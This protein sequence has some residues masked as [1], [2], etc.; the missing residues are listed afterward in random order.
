VAMRTSQLLLAISV[1]ASLTFLVARPFTAGDWPV[2]FEVLSILLL[3]MLGFRCD[4]L[5]GGALVISSVGD[6]LLGIPRLGGLDGESL[7]LFGLGSFLVAHILYIGVFLKYRA[8]VWRKPSLARKL[9]VLVILVA[10]A[11]VL[12]I[13]RPSL[14]SMLI[15]VMAYSLVLCCMGISAMLADLGN[16]LAGLG[17]LLFIAS[18]AMLAISKFRG[19]FAGNAQLIWITYYS[20]QFLILLGVKHRQSPKGWIV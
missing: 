17:A 3:S 5:L 13:L 11:S 15:P 20:A 14:G 1:A 7:F 6:F 19:P 18:D 16:P 8:M 9:G 12:G 2:I 10:L 4:R